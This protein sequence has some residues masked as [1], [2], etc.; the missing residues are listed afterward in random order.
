[1]A[2][3]V[4]LTGRR[5]NWRR[6]RRRL[7]GRGYAT[8]TGEVGLRV[9]RDGRGVVDA[10][11]T[12]LAG[13]PAR[14]AATATQLLGVRPRDGLTCSFVGPAAVSDEWATVVAL[15]RA[16]AADVPLAVLDDLVDTTYLVHP[17][18]GLVGPDEYGS[19]PAPRSFWRW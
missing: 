13:V 18:R 10:V 2:T 14:V 4:V 3:V 1:M 6:L 8:D 16:V 15:A 5:V 9:S 11:R 17:G 12:D 7:A 19:I